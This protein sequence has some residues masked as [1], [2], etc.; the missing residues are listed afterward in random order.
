MAENVTGA[1]RMAQVR[2]ERGAT[3]EKP[4]AVVS[5]PRGTQ[6]KDIERLQETLFSDILNRL[7]HGGCP[8][9]LSGLERIVFEEQFS[10]IVNQQ[11]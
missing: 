10:E 6:L 8:G 4:T 9:C 2:L 7:G 11:F 3:G 5:V 1:R